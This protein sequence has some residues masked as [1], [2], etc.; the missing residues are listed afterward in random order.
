MSQRLFFRLLTFLHTT[1]VGTTKFRVD[2][3]VMMMMVRYGLRLLNSLITTVYP[4]DPLPG[5][6]IMNLGEMVLPQLPSL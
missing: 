6:D 2:R 3:Q 4:F 1:Q 5:S